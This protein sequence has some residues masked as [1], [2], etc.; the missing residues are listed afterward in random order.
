VAL[1]YGR[2]QGARDATTE[3][4]TLFGR[5]LTPEVAAEILKLEPEVDGTAAVVPC[6]VINAV[7]EFMVG[8]DGVDGTA[9]VVPTVDGG[10]VAD[11]L[12]A[13]VLQQTQVHRLALDAI[14]A[15]ASRAEA[16][17]EEHATGDKF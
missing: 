7:T 9:A 2:P 1:S 15:R 10:E 14:L 6:D 12:H 11:P 3:T 17:D 8:V 5:Q 4:F 13:S 16:A